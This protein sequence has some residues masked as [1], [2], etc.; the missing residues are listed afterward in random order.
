MLEMKNPMDS[1]GFNTVA[2]Q[3]S[4]VPN[5]LQNVLQQALQNPKAFEEQFKRMN[6]QA[7]QHACSIRNAYSN[8]GIDA[9]SAI[10]QLAQ[11]R[12]ISPSILN[13]LGLK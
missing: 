3:P 9:R 12:G 1:M 13:S 7:Y 2:Q 10:M 11:A 8:G 5:N 4:Q 6:P